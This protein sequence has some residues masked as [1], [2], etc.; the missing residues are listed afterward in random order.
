MWNNSYP[1]RYLTLA[2]DVGTEGTDTCDLQPGNTLLYLPPS[3][4]SIPS[5]AGS[6]PPQA[7]YPQFLL[8]TR[9]CPKRK[10]RSRPHFR[11]IIPIQ[12]VEPIYEEESEDGQPV[13]KR[14]KQWGMI[15][16]V[17]L[18]C[19]SRGFIQRLASQCDRVSLSQIVETIVS[20]VQSCAASGSTLVD[21]TSEWK[22]FR[23]NKRFNQFWQAV[24]EM[25]ISLRCDR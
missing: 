15:S 23:S 12:P 21:L 2:Q 10:Q 9:K 22:T 4:P 20:G 3:S 5:Q 24:L 14:N 25:L 8:G 13:A 1:C 17:Q 6:P 19:R 11:A 18:G 16:T 7:L